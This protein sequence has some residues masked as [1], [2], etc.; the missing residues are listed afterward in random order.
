MPRST[1]LCPGRPPA[2]Q[3]AW[4]PS[5]LL[6]LRS[7]FKWRLLSALLGRSGVFFFFSCCCCCEGTRGG[8]TG[9]VGS[10]GLVQLPI[11]VMGR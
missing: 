5:P 10:A 8:G 4:E 11:C 6:S 3:L 2:P 9:W 1:A 7:W